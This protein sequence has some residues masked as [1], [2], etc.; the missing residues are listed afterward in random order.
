MPSTEPEIAALFLAHQARIYGFISSLVPNRADA[1]DLLQETGLVVF[2]QASA[3]QPGTNFLAWANQIALNKILNYRTRQSRSPL[4]FGDE[5]VSA[6]AEYQLN[7]IR[8]DLADHS[9]LIDCLEKLP[10]S[11]R[12]LVEDCYR[13]GTTIR[14][15]ADRLRRPVN[16]IYKRLRRI[17]ELLRDC[18][19]KAIALEGRQ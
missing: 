18:I 10:A 3:F 2:S 12:R 15:V 4:R 6:L 16:M 1:E 19:R 9:A 8:P 5:F 7:D 13:S 14:Q 17:R 11:E